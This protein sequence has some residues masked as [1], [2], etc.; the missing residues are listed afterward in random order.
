MLWFLSFLFEVLV[1]L[2]RFSSGTRKLLASMLIIYVVITTALF[3]IFVPAALVAVLPLL[4]FRILNLAR[5]V[6]GRMHPAYLRRMTLR[7]SLWLTGLQATALAL[8]L[9]QVRWLWPLLPIGSLLVSIYML[10]LLIFHLYKTRHITNKTQYSDKELP[11]VSVCIPARNETTALEES[12]KSIIA[13][14][15]PK[16]EILVL[17]DC[18][19]DK[20][21]TVIKDFAQDGVRFIK[22]DEPQERWL[23]KNQAY[24]KLT[25]EANGELLLFCGVDVRMGPQAIRALVTTSLNRNKSMIS[26]LPLR[27][28]STASEAFVRPMRYWW[29]LIPPRKLFRRPAVLSTC[30]LVNSN[31]LKKA[32]G[33]KAVSHAIIPEGHFARHF[34]KSDA[35][36]FIRADE[37]LDIRTTKPFSDQWSTA[38]RTNYPQIRRRPEIAF[39]LTVFTFGALIMPFIWLLLAI[40]AF[41]LPLAL[42]AAANCTILTIIHILVL[43]YSDPGNAPLGFISLP[44]SVLT[45][46]VVGYG[47]MLKYEFGS[48]DWKDRNVCIPVM[49]VIPK[50]HFSDQIESSK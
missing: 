24:D 14:D 38:I 25:R 30:W 37:E 47:S 40:L 26:V 46:I 32:G 10:G 27:F 21:A 48:V 42:I 18:S 34:I 12:L 8:T 39:L 4:L 7:T 35:Y 6:K 3:L 13:N 49:H 16:L 29:E 31:K 45:E 41:N 2:P 44:L 23:A 20:T 19:H 43:Q 5:I 28:Y 9:L 36:S 33:F 17:D 11:T 15:Y 1:V 50:S 22:G